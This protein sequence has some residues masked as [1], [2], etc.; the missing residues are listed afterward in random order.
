M[1]HRGAK[2]KFPLRFFPSSYCPQIFIFILAPQP[3]RRPSAQADAQKPR[4][5]HSCAAVRRTVTGC[6]QND[7]QSLGLLRAT[8]PLDRGRPRL[9]QK[10]LSLFFF[11]VSFLQ[12]SWDCWTIYEESRGK[13]AVG[14]EGGGAV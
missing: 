11:F 12:P 6:R 14:G 5:H 1:L 2:K 4:L 7:R 10:G 8:A 9:V 3:P 13:N